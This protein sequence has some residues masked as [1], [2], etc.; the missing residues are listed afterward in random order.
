MVIFP[1][2]F[3]FHMYLHKLANENRYFALI[4]TKRE[5]NKTGF[6]QLI[7]NTSIRK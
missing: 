2:L 5:A 7:I 4:K 1:R 6:D 3:Y